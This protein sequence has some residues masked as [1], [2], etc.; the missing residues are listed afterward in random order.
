MSMMNGGV[1]PDHSE[2]GTILGHPKGLFLLFL[3][4]MWERFSY[5]GMRGLL[6]LY[7]ISVMAAHQSKPGVHTN[8]IEFAELNAADIKV[9]D[10]LQVRQFSIV[11]GPTSETLPEAI[12]GVSSGT[13]SLV[14]QRLKPVPKPDKPKEIEWV[15]DEE[16]DTWPIVMAGESGKKGSFTNT[17]VRYNIINNGSATVRC[18][19]SVARDGNNSSYFTVNRS[20]GGVTTDVKPQSELGAGAAPTQIIIAANTHD[21]GRNWLQSEASVLYGWYTGLAYLFPI[22]GGIFADKLIGTHRSMLVGGLLIAIGHI[23]LGI[24]GFGEMAHSRTGM[25]LFIMGLAVIVLGTG[26]FK[27]T[28]SVMVGQ[29]Y[30]QGDPRRDGAF[31]IFYMGINLGA[32]ICAFVCGTLGEKV[33]WHWGFGSAAVGM[34]AGLALYVVGKPKY[35]PGIGDAPSTR[36]ASLTPMFLIGSLVASAAFAAA[37]HFGA[38]ASLNEAMGAIRKNQML[39]L[40]LI[41]V[42]LV[43]ILGWIVHFTL[44]NDPADRGPVITIFIFMF[45]NAFFW[46]AF[47]QAGSSIN[48][49]TEQN[50]DR[51]VGGF[52]VPATWF[53][54]V[55]AGLIFMLAPLFAGIW[56]ALGKKKMNPSQPVK[57]AL[58]LF[59]LGCGYLFMLWAGIVAKGGVAKA[60]MMLIFMTYFWHT[61]GELCL[62]PTGLSYVT[63]AA[64]ARFVSLL[65][66]IWFVSSFIANL[67]GGLIAAQVEKIERGELKMPW[68]F[69]GQAD[70]FMLFVVSSI[71]ASLVIFLLSPM[72]KKLI[73]GRESSAT[74]APAH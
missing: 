66:G 3:V 34:L 27:P 22:L 7:L 67:G 47:E 48:V 11:A 49:F 6:M 59:F 17:E 56:T 19:V 28:V 13:P 73:G 61:V 35:L 14:L 52:E 63:K 55:N 65:M 5:Y 26:H 42:V 32:F 21:S 8:T 45:F 12:P 43:G 9:V 33:G 60:S 54:S 71:G 68:S 72:L 46:L 37:Y 39:S 44:K 24:S 16:P 2:G 62:S 51:N 36:T 15:V 40:I 74:D 23:I 64:P 41:A 1:N 69:G 57:I 25:S 18:R 31:T 30:K 53:Q 38:L 29:L 4:E 70:F 20:P 50:T 10:A 58:G